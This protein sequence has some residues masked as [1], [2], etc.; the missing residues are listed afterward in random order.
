MAYNGTVPQPK[1]NKRPRAYCGNKV[2]YHPAVISD[3]K[4]DPTATTL[5][6]RDARHC[7]LCATYLLATQ[8]FLCFIY[9]FALCR[10]NVAFPN[11]AMLASQA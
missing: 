10:L 11:L 2:A 8:L 5:A 3:T 1:S 6:S 7:P 4:R 9:N